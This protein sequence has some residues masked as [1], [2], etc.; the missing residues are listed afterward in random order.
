MAQITRVFDLLKLS[1]EKFSK[2]D[3]VAAKRDGEWIKYSTEH[4]I[5]QVN[6]VSRG[7]IAKGIKKNDKV[8][9][10]SPNRPEWNICEFGIMQM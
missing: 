6:A 10:M 3:I 4:F 7:L 5:G 1:R 8:A 2:E 9:I